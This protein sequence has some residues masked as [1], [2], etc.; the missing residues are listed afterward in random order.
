[1][2]QGSSYWI[3]N[4][5][6]SEIRAPIEVE[7]HIEP[8]LNMTIL[9]LSHGQSVVCVILVTETIGPITFGLGV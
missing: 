3:A 1:M 8:D 4:T 6:F 5:F 7:L 2:F 9:S